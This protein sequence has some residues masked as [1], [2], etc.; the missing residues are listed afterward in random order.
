MTERGSGGLDAPAYPRPGHQTV[1][2]LEIQ[3]FKNFL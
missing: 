2:V 1:K 3:F